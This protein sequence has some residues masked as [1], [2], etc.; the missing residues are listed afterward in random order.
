MK[1]V[2]LTTPEKIDLL[3]LPARRETGAGELLVEPLV[4]GISGTDSLHYR[5]GAPLTDG[6]RNPHIPGTECVGRVVAVDRGVHKKLLGQRVVLDPV[7]PCLKC[8]WCRDGKKSL[9]PHS[10][11]LGC[12]P[13]MGAMQQRFSWPS[14]LCIPV[15][16]EM[17]DELA[18]LA[19]PL[20]LA[21]QFLEVSQFPFMGSAAVVGCGHLGLLSIKVLRVRGA[22]EILAIDP[23]GY[24]RK[25]ALEMGADH[26]LDP[27]EA[28]EF[29][30]ARRSG[31]YQLAIDVS[32]VS[33]SSRTAVSVTSRGGQV[34]IGGIPLDNRVLFDA[35]EARQKAI[36]VNFTRRPHNTLQRA[37]RLLQAP[38]MAGV[39][40]TIT[41]LLPLEEVATAFRMIRRMEDEV[42]KVVVQMPTYDPQEE[43][44]QMIIGRSSLNGMEHE[45]V[46]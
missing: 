27:I 5:R 19:P 40:A 34:L 14:A 11:I 20:S 44:A 2:H 32:N 38:Q 25:A 10:R 30:R 28:V 39:E 24:R 3:D 43:S 13:V 26:A 16:E 15:P 9:C 21:A 22:G 18:V 29:A 1:V 31:G 37:L 8:D 23:V 46:F 45:A 36:T 17:P 35:R 41:H 4:V 12:P 33:E 6:F 42:I 7:S